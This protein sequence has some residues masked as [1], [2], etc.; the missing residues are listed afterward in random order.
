[1]YEKDA[2]EEGN[3]PGL[4]CFA[5]LA[6]CG[7]HR[8]PPTPTGAASGHADWIRLTAPPTANEGRN[9]TAT[10]CCL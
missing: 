10:P 9:A 3:F 7:L 6:G 1:M 5:N 4:A 2:G 8:Q